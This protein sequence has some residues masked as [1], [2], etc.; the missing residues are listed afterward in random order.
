[1]ASYELLS[2]W[3]ALLLTLRFL[4]ACLTAPGFKKN[5]EDILEIINSI[6]LN[7]KQAHVHSIRHLGFFNTFL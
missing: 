1:M 5:D 4:Y 3:G 2:H 6:N 7:A